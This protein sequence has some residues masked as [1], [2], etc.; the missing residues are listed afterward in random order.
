MA[1]PWKAFGEKLTQWLDE[2]DTDGPEPD[3]WKEEYERHRKIL[4]LDK[5]LWV[6]YWDFASH[7]VRGDFGKSWY[8]DKPAFGLVL[9]RMLPTLYLTVA[10]LVTALVIALPLGIVAAL[11]RHSLV[12]NLC[13]MLAVAGQAMPI[14]WLG[15]LLIILL[16]VRLRALPASGYGTWQHYVMPA[17]CLGAFLAPIT[18]PVRILAETPPVWQI[19]LSIAI[20][21][22]AIAGL[23]WVASR[24]YRVGMLMYGKRAT[25]P[26]VWKW[27]RQP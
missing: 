18:M 7:A 21:I 6:Q 20:N 22:A 2:H 11:R 24:V 26:E 14:F 16:A 12:D 17:F 4:G 5:P 8:A 27:I 3:D 23:V 10:G 25:V 1:L 9:E 19:L 13:T 15:I